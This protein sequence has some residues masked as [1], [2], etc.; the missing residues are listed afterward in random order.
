MLGCLSTLKQYNAI[1]RRVCKTV[2]A[3]RAV[4]QTDISTVGMWK[5]AVGRHTRR[6]GFENRGKVSYIAKQL[7]ISHFFPFLQA[8]GFYD[9]YEFVLIGPER[10]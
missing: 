4:T 7:N 8:P 1:F 2:I 6:N 3:D 10:N 9:V 5:F